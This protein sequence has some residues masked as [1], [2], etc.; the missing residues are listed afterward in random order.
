M[1]FGIWIND[2]SLGRVEMLFICVVLL[3]SISQV[4][5]TL[6]ASALMKLLADTH[7]YIFDILVNIYHS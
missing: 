2:V 7:V 5:E 1:F 4:I 3:I 6:F